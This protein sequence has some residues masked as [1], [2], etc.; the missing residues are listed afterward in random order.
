MGVEDLQVFQEQRQHPG[1]WHNTPRNGRRESNAMK[2]ITTIREQAL[3]LSRADAARLRV[4][5][6]EP[7]VVP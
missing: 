6:V 5:G 2:F 7:E 4:G 3:D 1:N